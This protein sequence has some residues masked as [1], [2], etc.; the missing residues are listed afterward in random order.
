MT[1]YRQ[2]K[3]TLS[4]LFCLGSLLARSQSEQPNVLVIYTD[5]H[6]F[7][8]IHALGGEAIRT[9]HLDQLAADGLTF[10][11]T[12]LMGAFSGATCVPS[13]AMLHTGRQLFDLEGQGHRIPPEHRMMGEAFQAAGYH[14]H[15][16]GKW[17]QDNASLARGFDSGGR[18]MGRGVYLVD[19][20]RMPLWEWNS[21]GRYPKEDAYLLAFDPQ[22][23]LT[24][25]PLSPEDQKGPLGTEGNGP[26]TSEIFAD[27]AI[28]FLD[29]YA[30]DQPFLMYLAF[31]APHDPRQAPQ[32]YRDL[33]PPEDMDLPPSYLPQHPFDKADLEVRDEALAPWPRSISVA[34]QQL[35]DYYAII[36][37]LDAQ[38]GRVIRALK[39]SGKYENTIVL[40]AG[41]SGLA[42]GNHGLM[43]KQNVYDEDGLHVPLIIAGGP[44]ADKGRRI[45]AYGYIHDIFPTLCDLAGVAIPASVSG[46][47]LA[48]VIRG[49]A[50]QV[51]D[52]TYHAYKQ[53]E[54]A[55]R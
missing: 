34:Q 20:F 17:H 46:K 27:D 24:K 14:A 44:I 41:D 39:A 10:T 36:T 25:R 48:P 52:Y 11:Q 18:V 26:H 16:V 28:A 30:S 9:P 50:E 29:D 19:H 7:T 6:R 32:A 47:S 37:H 8:G 15:M 2:I 23:K 13:R 22:G 33:Y 38:I 5:D 54:R 42:V 43:G 12:Y 31:H 1:C 3:I 21:S 53:Y 51:R 4:V 45:D 40:L 35:S 49:E 55:Y